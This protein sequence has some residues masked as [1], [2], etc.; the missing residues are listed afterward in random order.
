M[1]ATVKTWPKSLADPE[2]LQKVRVDFWNHSEPPDHVA[3]S[4]MVVSSKEEAEAAV[5]RAQDALDTLG[6]APLEPAA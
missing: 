3:T 4:G 5:E 6:I 1:R 2:G